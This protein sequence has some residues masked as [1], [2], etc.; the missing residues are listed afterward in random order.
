MK[1]KNL[2]TSGIKIALKIL[3]VFV[4]L[5]VFLAAAQRLLMPKYRG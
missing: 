4:V 5:V 2:S 1:Q 3:A